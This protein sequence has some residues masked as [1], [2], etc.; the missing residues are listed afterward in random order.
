[1]SSNSLV[2]STKKYAAW[3]ISA[4]VALTLIIVEQ[5]FRVFGSTPIKWQ[6]GLATVVVN[7]YN[8]IAVLVWTLMLNILFACSMFTS[9]RSKTWERPRLSLVLSCVFGFGYVPLIVGLVDCLFSDGGRRPLGYYLF[10]SVR[11]ALFGS[12]YVDF[13]FSA[14]TAVWHEHEGLA[15]AVLDPIW[16]LTVCFAFVNVALGVVCVRSLAKKGGSRCLFCGYD[17]VAL[18]SLVCPECGKERSI[19]DH[20]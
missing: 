14:P 20:L 15:V 18:S 13:Q 16:L 1:M 3:H 7:R 12:S 6:S 11:D 19:R 5:R 10:F 8:D 2:T 9:L 17:C 4:I